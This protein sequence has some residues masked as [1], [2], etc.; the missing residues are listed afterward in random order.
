[1]IGSAWIRPCLESLRQ[2]DTALILLS[3]TMPRQMISV[4]V[5][6]Q[7]FP[8][9]E[10]L[11]LKQNI[12]FGRANNIGIRMAYDAG[13]T[14]VFAE[15]GRAGETGTVSALV[16]KSSEDRVF[17]VLSP[18]HL[19]GKGLALDRLFLPGIRPNRA[20]NS[21]RTLPCK[22]AEDRLYETVFVNAAAWLLTRTCIETAGGFNPRLFV[23]GRQQLLPGALAWL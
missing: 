6:H 20:R 12:G 3:W 21:S 17:A 14:R 15:P 23:W 7:V 5:I 11:L 8:Q 10:L 4:E 16:N 22:K 18:M 13:A 19:D 2:F 9:V 1:M